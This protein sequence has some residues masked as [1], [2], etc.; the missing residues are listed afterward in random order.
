MKNFNGS[1]PSRPYPASFYR[2]KYQ[3]SQKKH[4]NKSPDLPNEIM[5]K[6]E[7]KNLTEPKKKE[8]I[9][10]IELFKEPQKLF[11]NIS[12]IQN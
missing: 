5:R 12:K 6:K 4:R 3:S 1:V 9:K 7:D 2:I 8:S 11:I 10:K